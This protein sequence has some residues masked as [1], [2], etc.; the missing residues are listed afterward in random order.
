M[1]IYRLKGGPVIRLS[2]EQKRVID[3]STKKHISVGCIARAGAGKTTVLREIAR[4]NHKAGLHGLNLAFGKDIATFAQSVMGEWIQVSTFNSLAYR[5]TVRQNLFN[6][7][8]LG[9]LHPYGVAKFLGSEATF[10][11]GK[12]TWPLLS[13]HLP[14]RPEALMTLSGVRLGAI[15]HR[16][17]M[18]YLYS[19][20]S[21]LEIKH[22]D[23]DNFWAVT[24]A[25]LK[26]AFKNMS[27]VE[28]R[29]V[30]GTLNHGEGSK[31][32]LKHHIQEQANKV[33]DDILSFEG[34]LPVPHDVY[35]KLYVQNLR[36]ERMTLPKV[37]YV[38]VDEIQDMNPVA[39]DLVFLFMSNKIPVT[40][41]GDPSQHIF[42]FRETCD[43]LSPGVLPFVEYSPLTIS[44][45]FGEEVA[46]VVQETMRTFSPDKTFTIRGNP[47]VK[48][49]V[50]TLPKGE[51]Y[52][53]Y[54]FRSNIGLLSEALQ[55]A[56]RGEKP[57]LPRANELKALLG[58]V[59]DLKSGRMT[60]T[61]E[62]SV[63][64]SFA[65]LQDFALN[66][67]NGKNLKSFVEFIEMRDCK[68]LLDVLEDMSIKRD[69][70]T[71]TYL[72]AHAAKGLEFDHVELGRDYYSLGKPEIVQSK[73][74]EDPSLAEEVRIAVGVAATRAKKVLNVQSVEILKQMSP[75]PTW[76][77][78][79]FY[80][81][82][83]ELQRESKDTEH[84]NKK[85]PKRDKKIVQ[86]IPLT[87]EV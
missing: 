56:E 4:E 45:R 70:M 46:S 55:A 86:R 48:S 50:D 23:I 84:K 26:P 78:R 47:D 69:D 20:D 1:S 63:F 41:V 64:A 5:N 54:I 14:Q 60:G 44:R 83:T 33:L 52:D 53:A 38:L 73:V 36:E 51:N 58:G 77:E 81:K 68:A 21:K 59:E 29:I 17:V 24:S 22:V 6:K 61:P 8:R 80:E 71:G 27:S 72:T 10:M 25:A 15:V 67:E 13:R 32:N 42:S 9:N 82:R 30:E 85:S 16:T 79:L 43:A 11:L 76:G 75:V 49:Y 87:L 18:K 74:M 7:N 66:D 35:M 28:R 31:E 39:K 37:D 34:T 19:M 3:L 40:G 65:E 57:Y 2:E 12:G 62:L